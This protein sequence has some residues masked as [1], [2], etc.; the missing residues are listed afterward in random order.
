M[1][2]RVKI[3]SIVALIVTS[4]TVLV[5][6]VNSFEQFDRKYLPSFLL[7]QKYALPIIIASLAFVFLVFFE[8]ERLQRRSNVMVM[9]YAA[10]LTAALFAYFLSTVNMKETSGLAIL[11][12][13]VQLIMTIATAAYFLTLR[14]QS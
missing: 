3:F 10:V 2:T 9:K 13:C 11:L 6:L 5:M 4:L 1:N 14:P 8:P 12:Y 7:A